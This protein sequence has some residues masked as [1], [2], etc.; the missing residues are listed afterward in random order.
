MRKRLVTLVVV[1]AMSIPMVPVSADTVCYAGLAVRSPFTGQLVDCLEGG[2]EDCL[3]CYE[4][5]TG[6]GGGIQHKNQVP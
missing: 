4:G 2:G 5:G 6:P 3:R 1:L